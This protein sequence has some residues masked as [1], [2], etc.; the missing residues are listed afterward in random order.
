M[1]AYA[2]DVSQSDSLAA[3]LT[4]AEAELGPIDVL[5]NNAGVMPIARFLDEQEKVSA[6]TINVNAV[7]AT[8]KNRRAETPV[9]RWVGS[10]TRVANLLPQ[11]VQRIA[12]KAIGDD[13]GLAANDS[14]DRVAYLAR[15]DKQAA[16]Q[17]PL[18]KRG[19]PR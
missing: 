1:R 2:V 13:R 18:K 11:V 15:V 14:A 19:S 9:P 17:K 4:A 3:F 10:A 7:V 12:R 8:V 16:E 5:V 6:T